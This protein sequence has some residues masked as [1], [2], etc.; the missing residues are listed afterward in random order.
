MKGRQR[1]A[2][3]ADQNNVDNILNVVDGRL[4]PQAWFARFP[5]NRASNIGMPQIKAL[6]Q[7]VAA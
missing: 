7:K 2:G 1:L 5:V 4:I 3:E 6:P